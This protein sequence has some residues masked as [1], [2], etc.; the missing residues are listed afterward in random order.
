MAAGAQERV[1]LLLAR[2]HQ[3]LLARDLDVAVADLSEAAGL[4][5]QLVA[6]HPG[7]SSWLSDLGA[8]LYS[9]G[10][11]LNSQGNLAESVR[12]LA[13]AEAAYRKAAPPAQRDVLVA[14][15]RLRRAVALAEQGAGISA[16]IDAQAAVLAYISQARHDRVDEAY[17]GL[18]RSLMMAS[19][20]FGAFADPAMALEAAQQ[21]LSWIVEAANSGQ[22]DVRDPAV[23]H[24][25][26]R[27]ASVE[28]TLL[29]VLG[30]PEEQAS[31]AGLLQWLA[32]EVM[33]T[34]TQRRLGSSGLSAASGGVDAAV[35][36]LLL[37]TGS[38]DGLEEL[39]I[40]HPVGPLCAP[41]LRVRPEKLLTAASGAA[42]AA[43]LLLARGVAAGLRLGLEAHFLMAWALEP[44]CRPGW[45]G[46]SCDGAGCSPR[47]LPGW[48]LTAISRL[49]GTRPTAA[50]KCCSSST[51]NTMCLKTL[52][53]S[54]RPSLSSGASGR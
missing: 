7:D 20:V 9:L 5:R 41:A 45:T 10:G 37:M 16:V 11:A 23:E 31:A 29:V 32:A 54:V 14:D 51:R 15:V 27:A 3:A 44:P 42:G 4:A 40:R 35:R 17:L 52:S 24:A 33:P 25:V 18:A 13:E 53:R 38:D 22:A 30:R 39:L 19:D 2:G 6:E 21:G 43:S 28:L 34:L 47:W 49:P 48:T 1:G 46:C 36:S 50:R 26:V 12:V 8:V